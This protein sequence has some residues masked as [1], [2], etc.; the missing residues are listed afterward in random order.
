M[1]FLLQLAMMAGFFSGP[2][3]AV[4]LSWQDCLKFTSEGNPSLDAAKKDW[5]ATQLNE[6]V[7]LAGYLPRLSASTSAT[8]TGSTGQ[9][10]GSSGAGGIVTNGIILNS[11]TGSQVNTNYLG[12]VNLSQNIFNGLRD[13][14]RIEQAEWRSQYS[15]W[16]YVS[17]KSNISFALKDAFSSLVFAQESVDLAQSI[18]ERRESNYKLVSVRYE[19]GRE[20]RGSVL[21]AEAY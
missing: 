1:K 13:H 17:T 15:R 11:G 6:K 18:F 8:Q 3:Y 16:S 19:N 12:A 10:G 14:A 5:L 7:A 20:N 9:G 2:L 4:N 21:L